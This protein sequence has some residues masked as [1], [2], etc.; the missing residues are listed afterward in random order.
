MCIRDSPKYSVANDWTHSNS[1]WLAPDGNLIISIR[2]QDCV[3]KFRYQ[4]GNG[5]GTILW[6][7]GKDGDF[8]ISAPP[9]N[10]YPW[11]S[12]QHDAEFEPDG[13]LTLFDNGNTRVT[14]NGSRSRGQ[15]WRLDE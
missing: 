11:F 5:D 2:H 9:S 4:N 14:A 1:L 6:R 8:E 3:I 13:L 15:S 10:P 12:H 7:L